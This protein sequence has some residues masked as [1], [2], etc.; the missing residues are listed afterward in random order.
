MREGITDIF[1]TYSFMDGRPTKGWWW[2]VF[3][4]MQPMKPFVFIA[5]LVGPCGVGKM[6]MCTVQATKNVLHVEPRQQY[7][8]YF[9]R[10]RRPRPGRS[11]G[12]LQGK[13][14][15]GGEGTNDL[16]QAGYNALYIFFQK[17]PLLLLC[18]LDKL[19]TLF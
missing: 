1:S 14:G 10:Y 12:A 4:T 2:F 9:P 5:P 3:D 17:G 19:N 7:I 15:G 6:H 16:R 11:P 13:R 18:Y 8:Q